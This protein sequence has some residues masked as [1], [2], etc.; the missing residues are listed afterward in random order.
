MLAEDLPS[1]HMLAAVHADAVWHE[2]G[3]PYENTLVEPDDHVVSVV[4]ATWT[5]VPATAAF[6]VSRKPRSGLTS[7]ESH[8][9]GRLHHERKAHE[10]L[11]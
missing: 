1:P 11:R 4:S 2:V 3:V 6:G 9:R 10:R 8:R 5:T 7:R